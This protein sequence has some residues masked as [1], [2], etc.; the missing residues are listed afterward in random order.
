MTRFSLTLG[1]LAL[2]FSPMAV[3][4]AP[5]ADSMMA[6][7]TMMP[8]VRLMQKDLVM[9]S[10]IGGYRH[11]WLLPTETTD[12]PTC[13]SPSLSPAK[14]LSMQRTGECPVKKASTRTGRW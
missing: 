6:A 2:T 9:P 14:L 7:P 13:T 12:V 8:A 11:Q 10:W 3:A 4:Q 5:V 1:T